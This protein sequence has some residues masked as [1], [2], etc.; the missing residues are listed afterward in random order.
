LK[1]GLLGEGK[2]KGMNNLPLILFEVG[3][4]IVHG[5]PAMVRFDFPFES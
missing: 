4:K 3:H 1:E 2:F 5:I